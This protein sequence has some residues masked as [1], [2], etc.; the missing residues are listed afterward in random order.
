[1]LAETGLHQ[2]ACVLNDLVP[3]VLAL[4]RLGKQTGHIAEGEKR[5]IDVEMMP[6]TQQTKT[7]SKFAFNLVAMKCV[8]NCETITCL[9]R[10]TSDGRNT[11]RISENKQQGSRMCQLRESLAE[12]RPNSQQLKSSNQVELVDLP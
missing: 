3:P 10:K 8:P 4:G 5:G 6:K 9:L 1:M 2:M 12:R 11:E 7:L